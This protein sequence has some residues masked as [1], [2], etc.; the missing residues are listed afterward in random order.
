MNTKLRIAGALAAAAALAT[1]AYRFYVHESGDATPLQLYGNVDI[2]E[3][4]LSFRVPGRLKRLLVDEGAKVHAGDLLGEIDDEPYRHLLA[5]AT[6]GAA[7]LS[8]HKAL[9]K[10]GYRKE[11]IDQARANVQARQAAQLDAQQNF[12][13]QQK[14]AGTGA[15]SQRLLDDARSALDQAVAQTQAASAQ[16]RS[17]TEGYRQEDVAE[18]DA[19]HDRST[20]QLESAKLQLDD[21]RLKAPSDGTIITRAVEPGSM[22]AAGNTVL[23]LSLDRPVW[24]RA[25]VAEKDLGKLAPGHHVRVFTDAR[26]QPYDAVIG[27]ISPTA[28][29]TPKNVETEDLRTALVYRLRVIV[30]NPDEALRQGMAVTVKLAPTR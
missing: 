26:T 22:L 1:G 5:D 20:A 9:Y 28:E 23:T 25:Y 15:T 7:A 12:E 6:A 30:Q 29:F 10:A 2:R 17:L 3:V 21:T 19:N 13:R 4:N 8:A 24:I 11:D 18:V 14:L 16:L 27:F